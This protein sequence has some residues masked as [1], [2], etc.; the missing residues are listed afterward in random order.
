VFGNSGVGLLRGPGLFNIDFNL[1]KNFVLRE[2]HTLQFRAEI[3]NALNHPNF[4]FA[5]TNLS[6]GFGQITSTSTEARIIQFALMYK[7]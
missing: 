5:G 1:S 3:F 4:S 2:R 6:A 7:F